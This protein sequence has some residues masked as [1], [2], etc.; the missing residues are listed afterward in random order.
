MNIKTIVALGCLACS[1]Q[2][3]AAELTAAQIAAKNVA[4]RGGAAAWHAINGLSMAGDMDAGG[5]QDAKLPFVLTLKRPNKSRLEIT[6]ADKTALQ[7]YDGS[8]GWKY[9]PFL[10]RQDVEPFTEQ[11]A[12]SAAANEID[13]PLMDYASKGSK[14]ELVGLEKVEGKSAYKLRLSPKTRA[15]YHVWVDAT[16]FLEVK[17]E[18]E[19]RKLDN[20]MHPVAVYYRDYKTVAGLTLPQVLETAVAGV[21][22]T[23]KIKVN[24]FKVNPPLDDGM[25]AQRALTAT[26]P[27]T[28]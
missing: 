3:G 8:K 25:F 2:V 27:R 14:L 16:S 20:R 15:P 17:V 10:N 7:V 28:N 13:I 22:Q 6:F 26:E 11:E 4:A 5:K 24:T 12:K 1:F 21:P 18:G 9:R 19:P 23:H